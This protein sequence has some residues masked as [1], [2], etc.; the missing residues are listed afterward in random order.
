M[1][2][3]CACCYFISCAILVMRIVCV[4]S[5]L[6]FQRCSEEDGSTMSGDFPNEVASEGGGGT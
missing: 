3:V 5:S 4:N 1:K 2:D 6:I